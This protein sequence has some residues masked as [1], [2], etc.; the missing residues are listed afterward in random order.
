MARSRHASSLQIARKAV[1]SQVPLLCDIDDY[2][3]EFPDYSKVERHASVYTDEIL[4]LA[5][6]V[7]T[8]SETL[9]AL[10]RDRYPSKDVRIL[11]NA[12]DIWSDA[13]TAFTP[14][15]M[16]NSDFFRMPEMKADFFRAVRDAAEA[17]G[18]PVLLYYFSNDPPEPLSDDPFLRIIWMGFRSYSS[19][20][21]LL[22]VIHPVFG[23]VLLRDEV[24]S[25]Y[26]SVVK[27]AEYG[28]AGTIGLYSRV[29]PYAEFIEEGANGFLADNT[30]DG[31]R[32]TILRAL[33]LEPGARERMRE[34]IAADVSQQFS[35]EA[36]HA[37]FRQLI[38][39]LQH[40]PASAETLV[41]DNL[42]ERQRF[43]FREAYAYAAWVMHAERPRLVSE[44]TR[45]RRSPGFRLF[46]WRSWLLVRKA[47][48]I[49]RRFVRRGVSKN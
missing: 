21:E 8:P 35:Y 10:I 1:E 15:V 11:P 31:W 19:Y 36:L 14:C 3:W 30:Y 33:Q 29:A 2:V 46:D 13:G 41:R 5:A 24:F 45:V 43:S 34:R 20:K 40:N 9:A 49:F 6:C 48:N 42:P 32:V 38:D 39:G 25:R 44:L 17:A 12:G 26:K 27:F 22:D 16:A 28:Y 4:R 23:F 18:S 47:A 7:T 37:G